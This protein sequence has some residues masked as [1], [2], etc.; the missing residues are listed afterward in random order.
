MTY[1]KIFTI[2]VCSSLLFLSIFVMVAFDSEN[3][4][5]EAY[6]HFANKQYYE[7]RQ[8]LINEENPI[9]L[10]DFYLYE[11]YL[12]REELGVKKSQGYLFQA[13]RELA[14][15]KS[16]TALE[17]TLNLALDACLQK[18]IN[19]LQTAIEQ[20]RSYAS[21]EEPW[22]HFFNGYLAYL[23]RDY[24]ETLKSWETGQSPPWLSN[25]M[26]TSFENHLSHEQIELKHLHSNIET[27]QLWAARKTLEQHLLTFPEQY[28]DDIRFLLALSYMKEC[29]KLPFD[30]RSFAYQKA[31]EILYLVPE[32]NPYYAQEKRH[33][34][35]GFKNQVLLG[36][37]HNHFIDL[38]LYI[39]ALEKW[40]A[41]EQLEA[42]SSDLAK[43]FNEKILTGNHAEAATLLQDV[44]RSLPEGEFKR[45]FTMKLMSQMCNAIAR[46]SIRHLEEYWTLY[47]PILSSHNQAF[48]ILADAAVAKILELSEN[49]DQEFKKT[50][51]LI[52]LWKSIEKNSY[53]RYF[54]AQQLVQKAQRFWS[55]HGEAQKAITLIKIAE[56][57]PFA[58]E[59]SLIHEDIEQAIVKTYHQALLQDHI[60]EFPFFQIAMK[61][62]NLSNSQILDPKE[63]AN[64]L[65]DAQYLFYNGQYSEALAKAGWVLQVNP[66]H[67]AARRI[68]ALAAYEE[69]H[70]HSAIEHIKLLQKVDASIVEALAI[71]E[72]LTGDAL[73]GHILLQTLADQQPL[74]DEIKLRLGFSWLFLSQSDNALHWLNKI[75]EINDEVLT[76]YCIAAFQ[77]HDW[78]KTITIYNQLSGPYKQNC[79]LQGIAIQAHT[80]LNQIEQANEI[81]SK[82]LATSSYN[83]LLDNGSKSFILLQRQLSYFDANDFAA[84]YFLHVKKEPENALKKFGEIKR[85]T[86]ELLLERADLAFSLKHYSES[87]QDLQKSQKTSKGL[88]REK[89]LA[90]MGTIYLQLGFYPDSVSQF[91]ELF[92]LNP[93][94]SPIIHQSYCQALMAIGRADLAASHFVL[95]GTTP[96][97]SLIAPQEF[98]ISLDPHI[99][100][101]KRLKLLEFQM[102]QY[103]ESI[104]LQMLLA[105]ELILRSE[106]SNHSSEELLLAFETLEALNEEHPYIPEAWFMQGQAL[107]RLHLHNSAKKA[108]ATSISLNPNYA[109]AYKQLALI[110]IVEN[111]DL[112]AVCNLKQFLRLIPHDIDVWNSLA[113][114]YEKQNQLADAVQALTEAS[115]LNPENPSYFI[116][117]AKLNLV[118]NKPQEAITSI[119]HAFSL[120]PND[121]TCWKILQQALQHPSNGK[122]SKQ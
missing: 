98:G 112:A 21:P 41:P 31:I 80:A 39:S 118:L 113:Q 74:S 19:A 62:F 16:S 15:K 28:H 23:N 3:T 66:D 12:A 84:R 7:A 25:W 42:I 64:Q 76:G 46:G 11:A 87:L 56:S 82:F 27:G 97:N 1:F 91:K 90:L 86:P 59:Q 40:Q 8:L 55:V 45:L 103:P 47:Q 88:L 2:S 57:L 49:D 83:P 52:N 17:I 34:L 120:S 53:H 96:P 50:K 72:I 117:I 4:L 101:Q 18:D 107:E 79:A 105:K 70:Y 71:S 102:M 30:K 85:L 22:V 48:P 122:I 43:I 9:P 93:A 20:S 75:D 108:F 121:S 109:E 36:I 68:A 89:A 73:N 58:S 38:P 95:L 69:G 65:E 14:T 10:A 77:K 106:K 92:E 111:D 61:E 104:S 116:Q 94:Q 6:E 100:A 35:D 32:T 110:N 115:K 78:E 37:A 26:K 67:Q 81:F 51:A 24:A 5:N 54:L 119:E 13:L 60:D 33:V 29:D 114:L 63:T 44:S 99:S